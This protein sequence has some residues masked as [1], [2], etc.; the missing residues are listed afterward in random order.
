[1]IIAFYKPFGVLSQFTAEHESHKTLAEYNLPKGVYAA[2][3]LDK[4]SEGLLI[5]TNNGKI[6][7]SLAD[8]KF[9]KWKTYHCQVEGI[10]T[11][12]AIR[13]LEDGLL[14]GTG[15]KA[16]ETK[17][18]KAHILNSTDYPARNPPIRVRKNK[19]TTW[20]SLA[21][22]EGKNRQVRRMCAAVG[23]PV[24]RLIRVQVGNYK[25]KG[26]LPGDYLEIEK[27]EIL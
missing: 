23:F 20:I 9:D 24:L 19:P 1:M 15:N 2:G 5:L 11:K 26:L 17:K 10:I 27:K 7:H 8:P 14:I 13:Q 25:L 12:E 6:N 3:R 18:A 4:D 21:I 22:C 16:Y